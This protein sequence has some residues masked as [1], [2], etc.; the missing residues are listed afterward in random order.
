MWRQDGDEKKSRHISNTY[1]KDSGKLRS[2]PEI[3][4]A[5]VHEGDPLFNEFLEFYVYNVYEKV[6]PEKKETVIKHGNKDTAASLEET[7]KEK[8]AHGR[9]VEVYNGVQAGDQVTY[10]ITFENYN[11]HSA[12]VVITDELDANVKFISADPATLIGS[13]AGDVT[14]FIEP[15]DQASGGTVIWEVKEVPAKTQGKVTLTVGCWKALTAKRSE[16]NQGASV[17]VGDDPAHWTNDEENPVRKTRTSR[18]PGRMKATDRKNGAVNGGDI[19]YEI[20]Y[21]NYK[22]KAANVVIT[23]INLT[24]M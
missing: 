10:E 2:I 20:S 1:T 6:E 16:N 7:R 15:S 9:D 24:L 18:K 5:Y 12:D 23:R 19:T 21:K 14:T 13:A 11:G 3:L 8:A 17:Q 22:A 4:G